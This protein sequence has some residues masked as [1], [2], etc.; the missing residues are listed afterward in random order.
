MLRGQRVQLIE[1]AVERCI[2]S[3]HDTGQD[4]DVPAGRTLLVAERRQF[5]EDAFELSAKR[6]KGDRFSHPDSIGNRKP[7]VN[8]SR[9]LED[10]AA[11]QHA[12]DFRGASADL[13][14]LGVAQ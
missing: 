3:E 13:V 4:G 2:M 12:A 7:R 8:L 6:F 5:D 10:F 1:N 14:E 9:L 11:D